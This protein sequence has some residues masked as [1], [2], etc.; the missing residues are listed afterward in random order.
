MSKHADRKELD[1]AI[2]GD[3][4]FV[5]QSRETIEA[6]NLVL[7]RFRHHLA[8][9]IIRNAEPDSVHAIAYPAYLT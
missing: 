1:I 9:H 7:Q 4:F 6:N 8:P 5:C 3:E 2:P